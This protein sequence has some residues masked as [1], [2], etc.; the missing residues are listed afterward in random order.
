MKTYKLQTVFGQV[1]KYVQEFDDGVST[2]VAVNTE[3]NAEYLK[4]LHEG[5]APIGADTPLPAET[6]NAG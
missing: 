2:G 3:T 1:S 6:P 5:N 4:W